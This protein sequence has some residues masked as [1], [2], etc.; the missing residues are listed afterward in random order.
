MSGIMQRRLPVA[1]WMAD[2]SWRLPGTG[3]IA[4]ED[5]LQRDEA[6]AAQMAHRDALIAEHR[7]LVHALDDRARPAAAEL[8][9]LVLVH[10]E[11]VPGFA[12]EGAA[13]RRPDGVLV[14]L[15]GAPLI[16]AGRLAQEDFCLHLKPEGEAEHRLLGAIL[17]FPSNWTLAQKFGH[18]LS[19][20]HVP[21]PEY[22]EGIAR[23]VQRLFDG[24]QPGKPMMR[25]NLLVYG[26]DALFNPRVEFDR[27]RP[28]LEGG[29][30]FV[31]VE[32]QTFLRLPESRAVVFGIHTYMV[33]PEALTEAQRAGLERVRPGVLGD[34]GDAA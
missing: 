10:L 33:R 17:C 20:I 31:R 4:P 6:Y 29:A 25:A 26:K 1:P 21:V 28:E 22:D 13:L 12:R 16:A 30:R 18:T 14:P 19:R 24:I 5:W 32:R 7:D 2:H 9:A 34:M 15:D 27:H 23:R 11:G 3:P 8:L